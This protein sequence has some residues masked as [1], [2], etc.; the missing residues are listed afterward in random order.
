MLKRW[1]QYFATMLFVIAITDFCLGGALI[2]FGERVND[3]EQ[4]N[5]EVMNID[6]LDEFIAS[7]S[8][9]FV[10][11]AFE[12]D[13]VKVEDML[14]KDTVYV[15]SEDNSGYIRYASKDMHVEGYMATDRE[16]L[17]VRQCWHVTEEDGTITSGVEVFIEGEE[18]PQIWY[19]HYIKTFGR[20]KIF[21]LENGI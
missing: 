8:C 21:M 1:L 15:V 20:W 14:S 13:K 12:R 6:E 18:E 5:T 7:K 11:A 10:R 17:M 3:K 9:E 2:K 4:E 16:L 19:I